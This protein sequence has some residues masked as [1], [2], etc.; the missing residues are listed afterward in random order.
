MRE[1]D[2]FSGLLFKLTE[3]LSDWFFQSAQHLFSIIDSLMKLNVGDEINALMVIPFLLLISVK[4]ISLARKEL[5]I[6]DY[7]TKNQ[8]LLISIL[9]LCMF[10]VF[11]N[12]ILA[13]VADSFDS[14]FDSA[15][16]VQ[17]LKNDFTTEETNLSLYILYLFSAAFAMLIALSELLSILSL[18][19]TLGLLPIVAF[20][21]FYRPAFMKVVLK[22]VVYGIAYPISQTFML[23]I[24]I[25][26]FLPLIISESAILHNALIKTF[27]I[28]TS[29][30]LAKISTELLFSNSKT[31]SELKDRNEDGQAQTLNLLKNNNYT[32]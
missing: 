6:K 26:H 10:G 30:P 25:I 19:I 18:K 29:F 2:M 9:I 32:S 22:N 21:G 28:L 8:N 5:S 23:Y 14:L 7:F 24:T 1:A 11:Q 16:L 15:S 31:E 17:I 13:M 27:L 4:V 3:S 12:Q 20:L